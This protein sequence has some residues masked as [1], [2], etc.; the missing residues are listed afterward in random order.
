MP[1][2]KRPSEPTPTPPQAATSPHLFS[3]TLYNEEHP[4]GERLFGHATENVAIQ[5]TEAHVGY[6]KPG[7]RIVVECVPWPGFGQHDLVAGPDANAGSVDG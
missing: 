2:A 4:E 7:E 3:F 6:L 5:Y 1:D